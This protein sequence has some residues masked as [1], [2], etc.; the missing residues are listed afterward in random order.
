MI[1]GKPRD[2]YPKVVERLT[3]YSEGEEVY[4][5]RII[6]DA[7]KLKEKRQEITKVRDRLK[8]EI[9]EQLEIKKGR[10]VLIYEEVERET[11]S[12]KNRIDEI[13][14]QINRL[15]IA[16]DILVKS[17]NTTK[18]MV[19]NKAR[20]DNPLSLLKKLQ[21]KHYR[22]VQTLNSISHQLSYAEQKVRLYENYSRKRD[23]EDHND[24]RKSRW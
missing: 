4:Y 21:D 19:I 8:E 7:Q 24:D 10:D 2:V 22:V 9:D 20:E 13:D 16:R 14:S 5:L 15:Q 3:L 23:G 1:K 18:R 12:V 17:M 11:R 6:S